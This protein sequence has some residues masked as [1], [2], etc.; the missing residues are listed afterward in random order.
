MV[1][2]T[3][4]S[5]DLFLLSA[6]TFLPPHHQPP[7]RA[8]VPSRPETPQCACATTGTGGTRSPG[9]PTMH[10]RR[11]PGA[12]AWRPT[13]RPA[14]PGGTG[15]GQTATTTVMLRPGTDMFS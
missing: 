10:A 1:M 13:A 6:T 9:N 14:W 7:G 3:H 5:F 15:A 4:V 8:I 12:T 2:K 11:V